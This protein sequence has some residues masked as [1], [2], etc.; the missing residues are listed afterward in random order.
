MLEKY[1]EVA[2]HS[3]YCYEW[4]NNGEAVVLLHGGLS[5]TSHWDAQV[6]PAIEDDFHV[7]GYDR[8]GHGFSGDRAGSLHFDYQ[9]KELI[10]YLES[11]VKEP[12]H[13]IGYSDGG[14][15]ALLAAIKRPELVRSVITLGA[16]F[17]HS[18]TLP[19]PEFDG[20]ISPEDQEEY[21]RT[22]PD[23]PETMAEKIHRMM[24]IWKSEPTL[25]IKDLATIQC[26]V[27]VMA[28]DD[29][30][31]ANAHT[32]ELYENIPLG[33]LAIVPGASHGFVVEKPRIA[34]VLIQEFLED[35]SYPITKMPIRRINP[36]ME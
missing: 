36:G 7:F 26:P 31:I 33:Q 13:L 10:A 2:G 20:V 5:Q 30:V 29:D 4:D 18:G 6:L 9:T 3:L 35:L 1:L 12:A 28:G 19:L 22:S 27:L 32:I 14:N 16:N 11:V 34:Q 25:T 21:N 15:I 8:T 23:A 24:K 17:H